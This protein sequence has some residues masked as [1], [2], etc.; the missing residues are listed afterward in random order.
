MNSPSLQYLSDKQLSIQLNVSRQTIWR[1]VR[2]GNFPKPVKLGE[3]CTRW[4]MAD[5]QAWQ[6]EKLEVSK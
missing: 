3:N 5:V 6:T 2:E 4:T 1:W